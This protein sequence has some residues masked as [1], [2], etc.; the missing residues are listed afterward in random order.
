MTSG[1]VEG[2]RK[3]R[4]GAEA[5]AIVPESVVRR[6]FTRSIPNFWFSTHCAS[7]QTR[8]T[9]ASSGGSH[10]RTHGDLLRAA[11]GVS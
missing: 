10:R 11:G 8:R 5:G 2:P 9:Q 6:R 7:A 3:S 1:I 4:A